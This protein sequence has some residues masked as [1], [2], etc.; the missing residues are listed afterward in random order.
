MISKK[1]HQD[2]GRKKKLWNY[3]RTI[4]NGFYRNDQKVLVKYKTFFPEET[5]GKG[6]TD[7]FK[8]NVVDIF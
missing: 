1:N 5:Y 3:D 8:Q 7:Y 4:D 2:T 6:L